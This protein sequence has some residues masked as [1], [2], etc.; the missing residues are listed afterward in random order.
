MLTVR[1]APG[2]LQMLLRAIDAE[3]DRL[4]ASGRDRKLSR[5]S[6]HEAL[7][8]AVRWRERSEELRNNLERPPVDGPDLQS[9][10][11][12]AVWHLE[13]IERDPVI[14][15]LIEECSAGLKTLRA[16][17]AVEAA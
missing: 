10:A 8:R 1:V 13:R 14:P 7:T 16:A 9:A 15:F 11:E 17:L 12:R 4:S 5:E 3:A 2:E 6:R